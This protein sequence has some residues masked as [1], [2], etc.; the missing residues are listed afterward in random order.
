MSSCT[1]RKFFSK[2]DAKVF[3]RKNNSEHRNEPKLVSAYK[4]LRC[5]EWHVTHLSKSEGRDLVRIG[6]LQDDSKPNAELEALRN[7]FS[8]KRG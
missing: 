1:K 3:I 2:K 6:Y 4:C 5:G 8:S 7:K